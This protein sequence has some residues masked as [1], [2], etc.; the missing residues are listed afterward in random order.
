M[1]LVLALALLQDA[2]ALVEA[3]RSEEMARR[4]EAA[5]K[6]RALG[7]GAVDALTKAAKDA[8]AEVASR[9]TRVLR[10]IELDWKLT[11]ELRARSPGI[12]ERLADGDDHEWTRAL[13]ELGSPGHIDSRRDAALSREDLMPLAARAV[14]GIAG[15]SEL[16]RVSRIVRDMRLHDAVPTLRSLLKEESREARR[17]A[18]VA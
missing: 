16:N 17:W 15:D 9:A 12:V 6:L 1:W 13:I 5:T 18:A 7:R 2:G 10:L 11:K 3:L 14:R 8:D 4:D